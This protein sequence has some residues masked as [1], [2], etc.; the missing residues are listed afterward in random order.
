MKV[1]KHADFTKLYLDDRPDMLRSLDVM[2]DRDVAVFFANN[3]LAY[4]LDNVRSFFS[5]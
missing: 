4:M 1:F 5:N 2:L 3:Q